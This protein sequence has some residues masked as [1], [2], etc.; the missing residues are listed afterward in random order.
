MSGSLVHFHKEVSAFVHEGPSGAKFISKG[1]PK[2]E[3]QNSPVSQ[4]H[5]RLLTKTPA[6]SVVRSPEYP[7]GSNSTSAPTTP[8]TLGQLFNSPGPPFST[9]EVGGV[10]V[11]KAVPLPG[12]ACGASS[13]VS[14]LVHLVSEWRTPRSFY[15]CWK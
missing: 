5:T 14:D 3:G 8:V 6:C 10:G 13:I 1:H 9:C 7:L 15:I 11:P 12:E 4:K 2:Q